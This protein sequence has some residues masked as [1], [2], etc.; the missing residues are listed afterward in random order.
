MAPSV[1]SIRATSFWAFCAFDDLG[2]QSLKQGKRLQRLAEVMARG[3]EKPR[4]RDI[5]QICLSLCYPQLIC[6]VSP[7][8]GISECDDDAIDPV[9]L[10]TVRQYATD[11]PGTALGF[12]LPFDR[13]EGPQHCS[14]IDEKIAVGSQRIEVGKRPP[15]VAGNNTEQRLGGGREEADIEVGIEEERRNIGAVQDVLQII[16][17]RALA[18]QRFLELAVEG[19]QLLVE[20]LQFLLRRQQL[21]V[22]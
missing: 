21:F 13:C 14:C 7:L 1:S 9:I 11:V 22:R 8:G 16:G 3:S 6:R 10:G 20:R 15:N 2:Q 12:D 18:L 17:G 5:G 4:L 19:S